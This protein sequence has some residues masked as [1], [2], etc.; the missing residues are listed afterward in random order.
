MAIHIRLSF[1]YLS[2]IGISKPVLRKY[3]CLVYMCNLM[4]YQQLHCV[5]QLQAINHRAAQMKKKTLSINEIHNFHK[6]LRML[7]TEMSS[8]AVNGRMENAA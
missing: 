3:I 8:H 4:Q 7:E 1:V 5:S 2:R 6:P